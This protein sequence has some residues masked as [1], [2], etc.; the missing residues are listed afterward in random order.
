MVNCRILD[1]ENGN[2]NPTSAK[3]VKSVRT[4]IFS[5]KTDYAEGGTSKAE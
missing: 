2:G 1:D 4:A 5:R 3:S